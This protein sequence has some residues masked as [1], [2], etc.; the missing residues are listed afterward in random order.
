MRTWGV[1]LGL[2]LSLTACTP[3]RIAYLRD[4][5]NQATQDE[6]TLRL[7][8]PQAAREL[9]TGETVWRY[10]SYQGDLLCLEYVLR[11]DQA[12]VLRQWV[13]QRC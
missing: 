4:A 7:G 3:W 9:E 6:V 2:S 5:V 1:A 8:P 12:K 11:F 13:R 10:E